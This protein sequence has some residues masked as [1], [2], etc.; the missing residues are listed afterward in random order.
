[1]PQCKQLVEVVRVAAWH[2]RIAADACLLL[3]TTLP[4]MRLCTAGD[5]HDAVYIS[6]SEADVKFCP[7]SRTHF[8][9]ITREVRGM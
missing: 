2:V 9:V 1:M 5:C 7:G 3:I 6:T 8:E 4:V